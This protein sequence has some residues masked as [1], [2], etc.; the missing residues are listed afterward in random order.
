MN[1]FESLMAM[2][3]DRDGY[4]T[5]GCFKVELTKAEKRA[6]GRPSSPRWEIDI[7]AYRGSDNEVL[8]VECKSFIDSAG[9]LFRDGTF[10]PQTP[11]KL[12]CEPKL[13]QV[14]LDRLGKQ[15]AE[16]GLCGPNPTVRLCLAA[17]R[18]SSTTDRAAL[19]D[20]FQSQG[21]HLFDE[22]WIRSRL[23]AMADSAYENDVAHVASKI[24][25]RAGPGARE[26]G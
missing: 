7:V 12:F 11:Y 10:S 26:M 4:W 17:G 1:A 6:I 18:I 13:R 19:S 5:K 16:A 22:R 23:A 2:L 3:L 20:H 24:L 8:A 25:L 9:V 21:W 14:V 15:L